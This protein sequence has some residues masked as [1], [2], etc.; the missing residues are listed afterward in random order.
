MK[1]TASLT[2]LLELTNL[3]HLDQVSLISLCTVQV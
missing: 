2:Y 3:G 1:E